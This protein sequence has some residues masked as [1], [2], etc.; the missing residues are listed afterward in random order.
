MSDQP[1][2]SLTDGVSTDALTTVP[3]SRYRER[4]WVPLWWWP[5]GL[6]IAGL[7]AAEIQMATRADYAWLP[8]V[9]M[10]P[11]P[12]WVLLWMSRHTVEVTENASGTTELRVD[13]AHL[14][15]NFVAR[16]TAVAPSAKSA[17]LGRQLD[18]AAYVRHRA[19]IG[20]L[21]L[22]VLDDPD[23]PTP[24]WVISTRHPD[25]VLAALGVPS[26]GRPVTS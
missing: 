14:P 22:L 12:V 18:P 1:Q 4:L 26:A 13:R 2:P 6:A 5:L 24:Y 11:I 20:P 15:V 7:L 16:A 8:Y 9:L 25:R 19:W 10:A 17:A 3:V 21:A 23:D